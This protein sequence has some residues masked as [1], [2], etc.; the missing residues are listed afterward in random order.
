MFS[1]LN[2]IIIIYT[3]ILFPQTRVTL[4]DFG[5]RV[6]TFGFIT[7]KECNIPFFLL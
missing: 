6:W 5:Y 7:S 1:F 3:E 4:V 2:Y